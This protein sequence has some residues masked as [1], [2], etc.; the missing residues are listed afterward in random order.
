MTDQE[1]Q[2]GINRFAP[3]TAQGPNRY[4][5]ILRIYSVW[6][7]YWMVPTVDVLK[8]TQAAG[9]LLKLSHGR[10]E[11][12]RL[13]KLL[14]LSDRWS[15]RKAG[16]T[17]TGDR[18]VSMRHGPVPSSTYDLVKGSYLESADWDRFIAKELRDSVLTSDPG[19]GK[20][21]RHDVATLQEVSDRWARVNTWKMIAILH[22]RLP[23]W[24]L[25]AG[26]KV[27]PIPLENILKAVGRESDTDSIKSDMRALEVAERAA[28]ALRKQ[29]S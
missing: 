22:K 21:S 29:A 25:P 20:L 2:W 27:S 10:M 13:L 9:V 6:R 3:K 5:S 7:G 26:K 24:Q 18:F 15:L 23:E 19:K 12:I 1:S 17:V 11:Y 16:F 8:V 14:Y 28:Q 4:Q